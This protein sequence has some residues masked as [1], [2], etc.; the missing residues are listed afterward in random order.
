LSVC[1]VAV[2]S[3]YGLIKLL[4][5]AAAM[6][7][8][9]AAMKGYAER[10]E[11][12]DALRRSLRVEF[13]SEGERIARLDDAKVSSEL[14]SELDAIQNSADARIKDA[15]SSKRIFDEMNELS[16]KI[17]LAAVDDAMCR[18]RSKSVSAKLEALRSTAPAVAGASGGAQLRELEDEIGRARVFPMERRMAELQRILGKLNEIERSSRDAFSGQMTETRFDFT[19]APSVPDEAGRLISEIRDWAGRVA[20]LDPD[21]SENLAPVLSHLNANTSF[22]DRL[23][24]LHRQ[25]K[26]TL[27][28]LRERAASTAFFRDTLMS[29]KSDLS[30]ARN[31]MKSPG[32]KALMSRCDALCGGKYI[33]REDFMGLYEDMAS[34]V[35]SR[36]EE[37]CDSIFAN[38]VQTALEELGYELMSDEMPDESQDASAAPLEPCAIRYLDTPYEDYRV[39]LRADARGTVTTRL[40]R[41][42]ENETAQSADAEQK[43]RDMETGKK[44]CSDLGEF[45]ERMKDEGLPLDVTLRQE[46]EEAAV[47]TVVDPELKRKKRRK[48]EKARKDSR[49]KS[50]KTRDDESLMSA[51]YEGEAR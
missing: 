20:M 6:S 14:R 40:V 34:F 12:R 36:E 31:A 47:M 37:I 22:P 16:V 4:A 13:E 46:P 10:E 27:G 35:A 39:M 17:R 8:G 18:E 3:T 7:A 25:M 19:P 41:A 9:S 29:L 2:I 50:R 44:W 32:G 21:G 49:R 23:A 48:S 38:K 33:D 1:A 51:E 43:A 24:S 11:E 5:L 28:K 30:A 42:I 45:F 15:A 26:T